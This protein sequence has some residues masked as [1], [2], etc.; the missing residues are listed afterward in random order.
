MRGRLRNLSGFTLIELMIVVAI[1]GIL[2]VVAIPAFVRYMRIAKTSEA[3]R[4]ISKIETG[5]VQY[6]S[7]SWPDTNGT[8]QACQFPHLGGTMSPLGSTS[9][10]DTMNLPF[11][12]CNDG[13]PDGKCEPN[14]ANWNDPVW[15]AL[16][17]K[18]SDKHYY[19]YMFRGKVPPVGNDAKTSITAT[20]DLDCDN[21]PAIFSKWIVGKTAVGQGGTDFINC[22]VITATSVTVQDET[23]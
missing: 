16:L 2:A 17:F 15:Q 23:E 13:E 18:I 19:S 6:F 7:K 20:G 5:A 14:E 4:M 1:L 21:T 11:V 10:P 12:C 8:P 22:T 9:D 3:Y